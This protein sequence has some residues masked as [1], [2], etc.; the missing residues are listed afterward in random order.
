MGANKAETTEAGIKA[1][2]TAAAENA[3]N[4]SCRL[5]T[6]VGTHWLSHYASE[7]QMALQEGNVPRGKKG[8]KVQAGQQGTRR[9][10]L[11]SF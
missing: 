3:T 11:A 8:A 5:S 2:T 7:S 10:P 9:A 1:G 4:Q 6:R